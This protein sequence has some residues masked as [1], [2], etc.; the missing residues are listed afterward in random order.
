[1]CGR[2]LL[3]P[4]LCRTSSHQVLHTGSRASSEVA[5]VCGVGSWGSCCCPMESGSPC[6]GWAGPDVCGR[7][8][9][10]PLL[11]RTSSHQVLHTG[12]RAS[13]EVAVVC[14]VGS[15]G[16]CCCPTESGSPSSSQES[17]RLLRGSWD[18]AGLAQGLSGGEDGKDPCGEPWGSAG[19]RREEHTVEEAACEEV[20]AESAG[21]H[22]EGWDVPGGMGRGGTCA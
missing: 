17:C 13:S 2:A 1:V 20:S 14:G 9:L 19:H 8:L 3:V 18:S 15:W 7:A 22:G 21:L 12:S 10:V 6:G 4:L 16:S 11:C 5:V